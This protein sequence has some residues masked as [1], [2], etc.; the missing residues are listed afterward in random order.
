MKRVTVLM[1][2]YNGA[3]YVNEQI[4]SL[5]HQ[6]DIQVQ[7]LV[8]DDGSSDNTI[9]IL[10]SYSKTCP[11]TIIRG[12]NVGW[13]RSFMNLVNEAPDSDYYA[14]CD[15]DDIWLPQKLS[16]AV[17]MLEK[18]PPDAP[19][20]YCSNLYYYAN[21]TKGQ[22]IKRTDLLYNKYTC[23]LSNIATGCTIVF[24]KKLKG[25]MAENMPTIPVAHDYWAYQTAMFLGNVV[26]DKDS[27]ILYRQHQNNQ[28]G[29]SKNNF[30]KNI[31]RLKSYLY[32]DGNH[33]RQVISAN[34]LSCYEELLSPESKKIINVLAGYRT[35]IKLKLQLL[36]DPKFKMNNSTIQNFAVRIRVLFNMI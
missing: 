31:N 4:D 13:R 36:L 26:Y 34:L 21:N 22:L 19:N 28:I 18:L 33:E 15:Q 24:N 3:S 29:A 11:L 27:Y 6:D 32:Y 2:T 7:I 35:N 8:R 10:E 23:L 9:S 25:I 17:D 14:F 16:I 30:Q 5:L 20:L 12:E 1:S